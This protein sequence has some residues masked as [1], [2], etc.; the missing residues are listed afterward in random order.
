[1]QKDPTSR[2]W[3][4][5]AQMVVISFVVWLFGGL[6]V[7]YEALP[8]F[9]YN[10]EFDCLEVGVFLLM[11]EQLLQS[12]EI[13]TVVLRFSSAL[14][15]IASTSSPYI[16]GNTQASLLITL[17]GGLFGLLLTL[18]LNNSTSQNKSE[19]VFIDYGLWWTTTVIKDHPRN[20]TRISI[21]R[22]LFKHSIIY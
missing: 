19:K 16:F 1:M 21:S 10:P 9:F 20:R 2:S 8:F 3:S 7:H 4:L 12:L 11:W 15:K 14:W 18:W 5:L 6:W 13:F 22:I 17:L